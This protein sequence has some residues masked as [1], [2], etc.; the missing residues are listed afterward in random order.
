MDT[1]V[2]LA[3]SLIAVD[4]QVARSVAGEVPFF[5][6]YSEADDHLRLS[7][8]LAD[9]LNGNKEAALA[10][11][12]PYLPWAQRKGRLKDFLGT[13]RPFK[14]GYIA[15]FVDLDALHP[16]TFDAEVSW[17]DAEFYRERLDTFHILLDSAHKGGWLLLRSAPK[18]E[19]AH[20]MDG[21]QA[22]SEPVAN[23]RPNKLFRY[24]SL[25]PALRPVLDWLLADKVLDEKSAARII[26]VA[27]NQDA[28]LDI[29]ELAYDHLR[30]SQREVAKR[31]SILRPAQPVNG[32]LGPYALDSNSLE[33]HAIARTAVDFLRNAGFLQLGLKPSTLIMPTRIR[34]FLRE[35][36][37]ASLGAKLDELHRWLAH[38]VQDSSDTEQWTEAHHHAVRA[39]DLEQALRT[40]T[41]YGSDLRE[42]AVRWSHEGK[43]D[44]AARIF[45]HIVQNFDPQDAY[46]WEYLGFNL[47]R[48]HPFPSGNIRAKIL[49]AYGQACAFAP[50][51][52]LYTGRL[53]GFRARC[54]ENVQSEILQALTKYQ[55]MMGA[56]ALTYL[57]EP[58]LNG[59]RAGD[60]RQKKFAEALIS[61]WPDIERSETGRPE[62]EA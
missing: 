39:G 32:H 61:K 1:T 44:E 13:V 49:L 42:M 22:A 60:A 2:Q 33:Q 45:D 18:P 55:T 31:L 3:P 50:N 56:K 46:A 38:R 52:P 19:R 23:T 9:M 43:Y 17:D 30:P 40:A 11:K 51:N 59:L 5:H 58:I 24:A 14:S 8:L 48:A 16:G 12:E 53:L 20:D 41:F 27:P 29:L 36:A 21:F 15:G 37:A 35:R 6:A 4:T 7:V 54:G 25:A 28:S 34:L 47:A 62:I 26:R 10:C 57:G